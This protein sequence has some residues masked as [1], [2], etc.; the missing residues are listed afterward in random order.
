MVLYNNFNLLFCLLSEG[1]IG[2][3]KGDKEYLNQVLDEVL[4]RTKPIRIGN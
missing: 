4:R 1:V 3:A 2:M